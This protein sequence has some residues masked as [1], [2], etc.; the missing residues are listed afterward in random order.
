[1]PNWCN[2]T[3]Y[4]ENTDEQAVDALIAVLQTGEDAE[5]FQHLRPM[6]DEDTLPK[7]SSDDPM[8][9]WYRWR[10]TNWG[11]K[12]DAAS[13]QYD[14]TSNTSIR[15]HFDT[16]WGPPTDLYEYMTSNGWDIDAYYVEWGMDYCGRWHDGEELYVNSMSD[17]PIPE[18][19]DEELDLSEQIAMMREEYREEIA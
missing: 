5:I 18:E 14:I 11:T 7:A 19:I 9:A 17:D 2:N 6:P 16:A 12:W 1:M 13:V 4:L 15:L 8:P 10:L 3:V